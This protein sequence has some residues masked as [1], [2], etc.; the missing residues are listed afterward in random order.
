M[1]C[2]LLNLSCYLEERT[3]FNLIYNMTFYGLNPSQIDHRWLGKNR[4]LE[5]NIFDGFDFDDP[6][7]WSKLKIS[8]QV[9]KSQN[10]S[11]LNMHF[12]TDHASYVNNYCMQKNLYR[13]LD[14]AEQFGVRHVV[15]HANYFCS[16]NEIVSVNFDEVRREFLV[17][18]EKI[19]SY[20]VGSGITVDVENLPIIGNQSI[21]YDSVFVS[22]EDFSD[23][24]NANFSHVKMMWDV[25]HGLITQTTIDGMMNIQHISSN[26]KKTIWA[27]LQGLPID[28][29]HFCSFK[30][31]AFPFSSNICEEG[32]CP[33]I[34]DP[35]QQ[36]I[37]KILG[38]IFSNCSVD[39][40]MTLEIQENDYTHRDNIFQTLKWIEER[41]QAWLKAYGG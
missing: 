1:A 15:L 26:P 3:Y 21:D 29:Y 11:M 6:F 32:V 36:Q 8:L 23:L 31:L 13:F 35:S 37:S 20:L 14:V 30:G 10:P 27:Q 33:Q 22:P 16:I 19:D 41:E 7:F 4:G 5:A 17:L 9:A 40:G 12:P 2:L 18:F 39:T 28:Y 34:G 25:G 24:I 38:N